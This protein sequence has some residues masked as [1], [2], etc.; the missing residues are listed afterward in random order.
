MVGG[1]VVTCDLLDGYALACVRDRV[2]SNCLYVQLE[3]RPGG[4]ASAIR[5]GDTLWWQGDYAY[6]TPEGGT[7]EDIKI[8][9]LSYSYSL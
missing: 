4:A 9:R 1:V 5:P 6:W 7:V 3:Y 2:G 8:R